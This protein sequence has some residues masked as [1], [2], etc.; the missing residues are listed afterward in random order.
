MSQ[1]AADLPQHALLPEI[2]T[3]NEAAAY[4]RLPEEEVLDQIH[5]QGLPGRKI[6]NQWRFLKAAIQDWL[7]LPEKDVWSRHFG[8]LKDDPY[9]GEMVEKIYRDRA[10]T[11]AEAE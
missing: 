1:V 6:G 5:N 11:A 3:L 7:R 4:L 10:Q 9:L 2:L 8:A